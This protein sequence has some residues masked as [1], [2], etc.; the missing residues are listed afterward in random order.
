M[1]QKMRMTPKTAVLPEGA[2]QGKSAVQYI[3]EGERTSTIQ[4]ASFLNKNYGKED[5]AVGKVI[6]M[7]DENDFVYVEITGVKKLKKGW[8]SDKD[9][10]EEMSITEMT[11]P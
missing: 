7:G 9:L 2:E 1:P 5:I 6:A 4:R 11:K 8:T 10:L 3:K